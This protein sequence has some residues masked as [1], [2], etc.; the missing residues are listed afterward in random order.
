MYM[1][2]CI[3]LGYWR[4]S[5]LDRTLYM[6]FQIDRITEIDRSTEAKQAQLFFSGS[7]FTVWKTGVDFRP[8]VKRLCPMPI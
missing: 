8:T 2:M 3:F 5:I 7:K 4:Y 1:Y 6:Q